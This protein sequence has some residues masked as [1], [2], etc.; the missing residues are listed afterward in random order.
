MVSIQ[1]VSPASGDRKLVEPIANLSL[2]FPFNWFPQRVG[3]MGTDVWFDS[4]EE[5]VSIQLVSPASGNT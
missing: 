5:D 2:L 1:L 4:I 3:T